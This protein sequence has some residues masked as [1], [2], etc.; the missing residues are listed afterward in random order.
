MA[1][2]KVRSDP[3]SAVQPDQTL[4]NQRILFQLDAIGKLLS[5]IENS[6]SV[7]SSKARN[8]DSVCGSTTA[9]SSLFSS[10]Q[11]DTMHARL[12]DLHSIRHIKLIQE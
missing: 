8:S 1:R 2:E 6:A 10:S 4:I 3:R 9:S 7:A 5:V 11:E 12:P